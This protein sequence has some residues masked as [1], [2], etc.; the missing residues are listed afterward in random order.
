V[1]R[2]INE[3]PSVTPLSHEYVLE[4][5]EPDKAI[6]SPVQIALSESSEFAITFGREFTVAKILFVF[7][8]KPS[9]TVIL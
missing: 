9:L 6:L 7:S 2:G 3:T 8:Q 5:P 4:F 1:P